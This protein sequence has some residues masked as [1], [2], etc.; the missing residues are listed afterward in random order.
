[1]FRPRKHTKNLLS[2][3]SNQPAYKTQKPTQILLSPQTTSQ[4]ASEP[5]NEN[6]SEEYTYEEEE[7]STP[8][9]F[10]MD[11]YLDESVKPEQNRY[12]INTFNI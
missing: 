5:E 6:L 4:K 11:E 1:M 8:V 10:C 3:V 12:T 9:L 7:Y 2:C